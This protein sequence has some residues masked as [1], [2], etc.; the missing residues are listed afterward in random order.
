MVSHSKLV[1]DAIYEEKKEK[2]EK[3]NK[4]R[5]DTRS[6]LKNLNRK[7][8]KSTLGDMDIL[9]QLKQKLDSSSDETAADST[10]EKA[11]E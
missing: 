4:E 2:T 10:E 6:E 8:E 9:S 1:D 11:A 7:V 3:V 5:T